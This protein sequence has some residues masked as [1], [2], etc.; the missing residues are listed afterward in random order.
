MSDFYGVDPNYPKPAN[1]TDEP[2]WSEDEKKVLADAKGD[3]DD[4]R[5]IV[6]SVDGVKQGEDKESESKE[7]EKE[8]SPKTPVTPPVAPATPAVPKG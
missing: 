8:E 7:E 1:E 2:A 4:L 3:S 6:G 5:E